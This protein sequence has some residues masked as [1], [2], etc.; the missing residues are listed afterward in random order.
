M[1]EY[2]FDAQIESLA[3]RGLASFRNTLNPILGV[4]PKEQAG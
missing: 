1:K 4:K 2:Q 3:K